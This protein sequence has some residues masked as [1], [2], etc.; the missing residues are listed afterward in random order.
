MQ[1]QLAVRYNQYEILSMLLY[2]GSDVNAANDRG[3]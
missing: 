1:V 2:Q 3:E